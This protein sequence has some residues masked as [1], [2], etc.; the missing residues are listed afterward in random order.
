[1]VVEQRESGKMREGVCTFLTTRSALLMPSSRIKSG[2]L[3]GCGTIAKSV[4]DR[5]TATNLLHFSSRHLQHDDVQGED[6]SFCKDV[7]IARAGV[8]TKKKSNRAE[9]K[10]F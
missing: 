2:V 3:D 10:A 4:S 8:D 6:L 1:M 5:L 9:M 7:S